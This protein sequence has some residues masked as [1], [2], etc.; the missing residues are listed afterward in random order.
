M[1][2]DILI[3]LNKEFTF[4]V[5]RKYK[6]YQIIGN[7]FVLLQISLINLKTFNSLR[8]ANY[9]VNRS[10]FYYNNRCKLLSQSVSNSVLCFPAIKDTLQ[11]STIYNKK[12]GFISQYSFFS[13]K[14]C[15]MDLGDQNLLWGC[16]ILQSLV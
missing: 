10:K 8:N 12:N 5:F 11:E 6:G 4:I 16:Q 7:V 13:K 1:Y 14:N 2:K 15:I 9:L 3:N